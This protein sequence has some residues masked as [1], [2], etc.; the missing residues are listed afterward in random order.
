[1]LLRIHAY[2]KKVDGKF[3]TLSLDDGQELRVAQ[4]DSDQI[5]QGQECMV[6]IQTVAE[7]QQS[8]TE[9]AH[10]IL[11]SILVNEEAKSQSTGEGER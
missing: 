4:S 8:T 10:S 3:M 9:L 7:A 6:T 5:A 1:M 2:V 11:N